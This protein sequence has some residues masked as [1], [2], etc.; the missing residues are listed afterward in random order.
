VNLKFDGFSHDPQQHYVATWFKCDD[1]LKG[2]NILIHFPE[3][4]PLVGFFGNDSNDPQYAA[5]DSATQTQPVV[6]EPEPVITRVS[7]AERREKQLQIDRT[8]NALE[9]HRKIAEFVL[10]KRRNKIAFANRSTVVGRLAKLRQQWVWA[11]DSSNP[12]IEEIL[13]DH[14][15]KVIIGKLWEDLKLIL[16]MQKKHGKSGVAAQRTFPATLGTQEEVRCYL[17]SA[18]SFEDA[19]KGVLQTG[20]MF[21]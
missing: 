9:A 17:F 12:A 5:A 2:S 15:G 21:S 19:R 10:S 11:V 8:A 13:N 7:E 6:A 1:C 16:T 18:K 20:A 3:G 4:K 14:G